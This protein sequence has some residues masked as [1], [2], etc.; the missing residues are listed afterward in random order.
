MKYFLL[1]VRWFVGILFIFSGLIKANDPLGLS[2]KMQEFFEVW[3][4][5]GL[6]D[7]TLSLAIVLNVFE[8]VA[9]IAVII[10]WQMRLVNWLLLLLI[11]AFTFLTAY[12]LF[13]GKIKTC[14]CFGDCIPLTSAQSFIKD[15]VLL[16]L[17]LVLFYYQKKMDSHFPSLLAICFLTIG[18]LGS[19]IF[20]GYTLK[21]LPI[22]DCLPF[23][24]ENN[25]LQQMQTPAG[26]IPDSFALHFVYQKNG[27]QI[28]FDQAHFPDD[29]DS[30]YIYVDR[31]D[32]LVKPGNGLKAAITDFSLRTLLDTDTTAALF[33]SQ[34]YV[35]ILAKD[36]DHYNDW[37]NSI[38]DILV[39]AKI[40]KLSVL[41]VTA[42][43]KS[44]VEKI[45]NLTILKCD[46]TVLKTAARVTPTI[47][48]MQK[49]TIVEKYSYADASS[50]MNFIKHWN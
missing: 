48:F 35:L 13:S 3:G 49:A 36:F 8:I 23:K 25:I 37:K 40:H 28:S 10:G 50:A 22:V 1:I 15:L 29:F 45:S 38:A 4:W 12:A 6:H 44:A 26:A 31:K 33:E 16:C 7:Y 46:A 43:V 39:V 34:K 5:H 18:L 41:L 14:G 24:K 30:T 27:K 21:H 20:Q 47:F 17:I 19:A 9:G 2:Y 11:L 32:E 42:D